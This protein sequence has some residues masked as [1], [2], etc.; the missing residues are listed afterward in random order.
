MTSDA[1]DVLVPKEILLWSIS[2]AGGLKA[3][4]LYSA[5]SDYVPMC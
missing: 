4:V 2:Q 1:S 3:Y 5:S